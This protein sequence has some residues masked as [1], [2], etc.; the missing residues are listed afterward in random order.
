MVGWDAADDSTERPRQIE[1]WLTVQRGH[2]VANA[3]P[4][5]ACN[6]AGHEPHPGGAGAGID[7]WGSSFACGPQG[8]IIAKAGH[9]PEILTAKLDMRRSRQIRRIWPFLRDRRIDA[10][11]ALSLLYDD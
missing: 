7:F 2:A 5:L 11:D 3:L 10:Y 8:E 4:L 9:S 6:R 1:S